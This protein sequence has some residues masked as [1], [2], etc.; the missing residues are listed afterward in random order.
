M[1]LRIVGTDLPGRQCDTYDNVHVGIQIRRDPE[2]VVPADADTVTFSTEI[3]ST[4][5]PPPPSLSQ[6]LPRPHRPTRS[7]R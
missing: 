5:S 3:D 2:Q 7:D 1:E 6:N 4:P